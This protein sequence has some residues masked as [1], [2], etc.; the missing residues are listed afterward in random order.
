VYLG[1]CV[2]GGGESYLK[3]E[4]QFLKIRRSELASPLWAKLIDGL[5]DLWVIEITH[6]DQKN[7]ELGNNDRYLV[8]AVPPAPVHSANRRNFNFETEE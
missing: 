6:F 5:K 2:V 8:V 3:L 7:A 4:Q 1:L